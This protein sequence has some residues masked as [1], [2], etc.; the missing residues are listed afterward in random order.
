MPSEIEWGHQSVTPKDIEG[1]T[2]A[3]HGG[4][5]RAL[6]EQL[7]GAFVRLL[8]APHAVAM[9]SVGCAYQALYSALRVGPDDQIIT[10]PFTPPAAVAAALAR[11]ARLILVDLGAT[12]YPT[13]QRSRGR[14]I[15][16]VSH[17]AG[18]PVALDSI[19]QQLTSPNDV[20]IEDASDA[21]GATDQDG[22]RI[23]ACRWSRI[24]LFDLNARS[25]TAGSGAILMTHDAAL[26]EQLRL[27]RSGGLG[28]SIAP[29]TP[30]GSYLAASPLESGLPVV[31]TYGIDAHL[32][33]LAAALGLSQ[34][35]KLERF[36]KRRRQ[37][38]DWYREH[39]TDPAIQ[40]PNDVSHSACA[41][42]PLQVDWA[43][44]KIPRTQL[45]HALTHQG[46]ETRV[47][48]PLHHHPLFAQEVELP[49]SDQFFQKLLELP[50]YP[51][52]SEPQI[53]QIC[54]ALRA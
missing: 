46:I 9:S 49:L 23:G 54:A 37:V 33:P 48:V 10:T 40:H 53:Q 11:G 31:V 19:E 47:T 44:L 18:T 42:L 38:M 21:L 12:S 27:L 3:L 39:L 16:I 5:P 35:E 29:S 8:G 32:N 28:S 45:R 13:H 43:A 20:L 22:T 25:I 2:Q 50:V 36:I 15:L 51:A 24:T 30:E 26:A 6:E 7:E 34:L 14:S 41:F 52:L 1:V 17:Y 4:M